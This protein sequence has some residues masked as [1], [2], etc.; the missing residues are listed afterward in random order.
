MVSNVQSHVQAVLMVQIKLLRYLASYMVSFI[1]NDS[2]T[3]MKVYIRTYKGG[4][5]GE[6]S[7]EIKV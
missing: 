1:S 5:G 7:C 3:S 4:T 6:R 2:D